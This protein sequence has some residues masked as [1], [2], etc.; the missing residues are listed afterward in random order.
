MDLSRTSLPPRATE[1]RVWVLRAG[2]ELK[3]L[4]TAIRQELAAQSPVP[5][6]STLEVV[7]N[8]VLVATELATNAIKHGLPPTTVRLLHTANLFVLDVADDDLSTMPELAT[9]RPADAGGHG[10]KLAGAFATEIGWYLA[11]RTKHIWAT[12]PRNTPS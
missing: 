3:D 11:Q 5:A 10:L 9:G 7:D 6:W 12:F 8:M 1:L 2:T 4:R